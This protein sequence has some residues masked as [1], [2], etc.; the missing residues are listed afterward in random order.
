MHPREEAFRNFLHAT[1]PAWSQTVGYPAWS[2]NHG[3]VLGPGILGIPLAEAPANCLNG[4]YLDVNESPSG[5][6]EMLAILDKLLPGGGAVLN[7][8]SNRWKKKDIL[9][10]CR[11]SDMRARF[12]HVPREL[13]PGFTVQL[14]RQP[15]AGPDKSQH[16]LSV[17]L[18]V[19]TEDL[20]HQQSVL[21][22]W[23]RFLGETFRAQGDASETQIIVVHDGVMPGEEHLEIEGIFTGNLRVF[24]HYRAFGGG[25]A[26]RTGLMHASGRRVLVDESAGAISPDESLALLEP[27][28][29]EQARVSLEKAARKAGG[30]SPAGKP[31]GEPGAVVGFESDALS[32]SIYA[33]SLADMRAGKF[34]RARRRRGRNR[35]S[36]RMGTPA[37][38]SGFRLYSAAAARTIAREARED[39]AD[40]RLESLLILKEAGLRVETTPVTVTASR[41]LPSPDAIASGANSDYERRETRRV[42]KYKRPK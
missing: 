2:E 29:E 15:G 34:A 3:E 20:K 38:E 14:E 39:G 27:W 31:L 8:D 6:Y 12:P 16:Q 28:M 10:I 33:P 23:T 7:L 11:G 19:L 1:I 18:P 13:N 21:L 9:E 32:R 17:I 37:P 26:V 36:K 4:L 40:L 5:L 35:R 25:C 24:H 41:G 22:S 42:L 30:E